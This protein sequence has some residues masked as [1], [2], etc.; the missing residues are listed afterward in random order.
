MGSEKLLACGRPLAVL[1]RVLP[2]Q[3]VTGLVVKV[4]TCTTIQG[5]GGVQLSTVQGGGCGAAQFKMGGEGDSAAAQFKVGV[6]AEFKVGGRVQPLCA[7]VGVRMA[8]KLAK[9]LR[10]WRDTTTL[11]RVLSGEGL[12]LS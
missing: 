4:P 6:C 12:E 3:A 2:C 10:R 8:R 1:D 9:P 7:G 11:V 5:V